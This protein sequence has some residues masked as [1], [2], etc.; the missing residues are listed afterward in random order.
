MKK[1]YAIQRVLCPHE[2]LNDA[3]KI[4][5]I[6]AM[7]KIDCAML[8]NSSVRVMRLVFKSWRVEIAQANRY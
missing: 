1:Y 6:D 4:V 2:K 7:R 3:A 8:E 5:L